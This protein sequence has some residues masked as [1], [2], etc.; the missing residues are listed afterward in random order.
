MVE[1]LRSV[2]RLAASMHPKISAFSGDFLR[3][4]ACRKSPRSGMRDRVQLLALALESFRSGY[5]GLTPVAPARDP[6]QVA[7]QFASA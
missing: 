3:P 1:L 6:H 7:F 2:L 5:H 4:M